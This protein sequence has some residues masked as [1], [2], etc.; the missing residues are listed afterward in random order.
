MCYSARVRQD[1]NTLIRK[2]GAR[3][4]W[5]GFELLFRR[6]LEDG[7]IKI[8]RALEDNFIEPPNAVAQRTREHIEVFRSAQATAW[9]R[10]LFKQKKRLADAQRSLLSKDTRKARE[11]QRIASNKIDNYVERLAN[12]GRRESRPDDG[13]IFPMYFAPVVVNEGNHRIIRPMRYTCRLAGKPAF[14]DRKFPGTYNA[15]R[16][17][18]E[19]FWSE[20]YGTNHAV[21]LVDSFFE[22][23][24][25]HLFERRALGDGEPETNTVLHFQ[26]NPPD[27]M[28]VACLWSHW[29]GQDEP[30][31][32]SFAAITDEPPP[33]IAA[34]GHQRCIICLQANS[35]A[36]W[37]AP[38]GLTRGRLE[39]ILSA[40]TPVIYEHRKAA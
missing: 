30:D 6:R 26:P 11:D 38:G 18:L 37:L 19:G 25:T 12:L 24:P 34:T 22:N 20:A 28:I 8:S 2:F 40:R 39:E 13:R 36:E 27:A 21:M 4:D 5:E 7:S 10:D 15:R 33:E 9:E 3:V 35:V 29:S 32:D 31:L 16:D 17:N 1:L 23:V 14:Y